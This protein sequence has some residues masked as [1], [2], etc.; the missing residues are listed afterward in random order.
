MKPSSRF[1]AEKTP[2]IIICHQG[3]ALPSLQI[4]RSLQ[5]APPPPPPLYT[6]RGRLLITLKMEQKK[7]R[8]I[9]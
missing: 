6:L 3:I 4:L 8:K 1:E 7:K 9:A 5:N 2:P